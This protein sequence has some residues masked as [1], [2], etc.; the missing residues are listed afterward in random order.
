MKSNKSIK[1]TILLFL[2]VMGVT[3]I[4]IYSVLIADYFISGID[5][6]IKIRLESEVREYE[7]KYQ[8]N[9]DTP[10]PQGAY[11]KVYVGSELLPQPIKDQLSSI[12]PTSTPTLIIDFESDETEDYAD[13]WVSSWVRPDGTT[14]YFV[15]EMRDSAVS[16]ENEKVFEDREMFLFVMAGILF[17][18]IVG[19]GFFLFRKIVRPVE[20]I[21]VW[22][23]GLVEENLDDEV[24][25]TYSELNRL[26]LLFRAT[27]HRMLA[28]V[29][30][31]QA[32][33][34][35]ASHELRTPI[36][37]MQNNLELIDECLDIEEGSRAPVFLKR[38]NNAVVNMR[39]IT[40]TLLWASKEQTEPLEQCE[41]QIDA[42]INE[43]ISENIYLLG[44]KNITIEKSL[45]PL[46]LMVPPSLLRIILS[47]II[48]NAFQHSFNGVISITLK[49]NVFVVRNEIYSAG[50]QETQESYGIG[51]MLISQL[52]EKLKWDL[53]LTPEHNHFTV[54]L[55]LKKTQQKTFAV[56]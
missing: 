8:K 46:S 36:A 17:L 37:I 53:A 50:T 32:F 27:M 13:F 2:V 56:S 12:P 25:F 48:R 14:L 51:L 24:D 31:E 19:M 49:D 5:L 22:S 44:S 18:A 35:N 26:A 9:P 6:A 43:L 39:N 34:R 47:N 55:T 30:R 28:G 20:A 1:R 23:E 40:S 54:K 15:F 41:E 45:S 33:L 29:K 3:V 10:L 4:C 38:M 16:E 21:S 52:V 42:L 11:F 7:K